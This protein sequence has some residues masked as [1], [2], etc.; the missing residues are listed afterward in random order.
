[1]G[2]TQ[3]VLRYIIY[4]RNYIIIIPE[5]N[6]KLYNYNFLQYLYKMYCF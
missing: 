3:L 1:M 6:K 2:N 5:L 4:L